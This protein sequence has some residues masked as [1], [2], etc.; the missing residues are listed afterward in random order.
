MNRFGLGLSLA[1][2]L[3][4]VGF[5]WYHVQVIY[6][7]RFAQERFAGTFVAGPWAGTVSLAVDRMTG[8]DMVIARI[9]CAGCMPNVASVEI[10]KVNANGPGRLVLHGPPFQATVRTA[11]QEA[12]F[13]ANV[14]V[15]VRGPDG[16]TARGRVR[17]AA[18]R[19]PLAPAGRE[20]EL[21]LR[22]TLTAMSLAT[23]A[24]AGAFLWL[25]R[26]RG[27]GPRRGPTACSTHRADS[28]IRRRGEQ[29]EEFGA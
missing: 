3:L 26:R 25:A 17:A 19:Q 4:A 27:G 12:G 13:P 2:M 22:A 11:E 14:I 8:S 10:E 6:G 18:D 28:R 9:A 1:V 29:L 21:A 16:M 20:L 15:V 24:G 5:G 23:V 7:P